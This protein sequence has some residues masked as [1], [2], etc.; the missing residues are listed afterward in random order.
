MS[1]AAIIVAPVAVCCLLLAG[2]MYQD[3]QAY[4]KLSPDEQREY[5]VEMAQKS[6]ERQKAQ[7]EYEFKQKEQR[8][9]EIM[10]TFKRLNEEFPKR[11]GKGANIIDR[12]EF[13]LDG[14][15]DTKTV[16]VYVK[17]LWHLAPQS[18]RIE[19]TRGIWRAFAVLACPDNL[20][21]AHVNILDSNGNRVAGSR[22][23]AGSL[24]WAKE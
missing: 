6:G 18:D 23:L 16:D 11:L 8:Q 22:A 3:R 1:L 15:Q 21:A 12:Y 13:M 7:R 5:R 17:P 2:K 19:A 9:K 24:I 20:D 14:Y 4:L 10:A